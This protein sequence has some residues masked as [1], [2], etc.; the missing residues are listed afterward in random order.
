MGTGAVTPTTLGRPAQKEDGA[1]A[2]FHSK[3]TP[4]SRRR[5]T[6]T[7]TSAS[8]PATTYMIG[9][10]IRH[11]SMTERITEHR[12]PRGTTPPAPQSRHPCPSHFKDTSQNASSAAYQVGTL[13]SADDDTILRFKGDRRHGQQG[14]M[15]V[16]DQVSTSSVS[17][18]FLVTRNLSPDDGSPS[19]R[20]TWRP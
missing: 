16:T 9:R 1:Q 17:I 20:W 4:C 11:D 3:E 6:H 13:T 12:K 18:N 2:M 15:G 8:C 7:S 19:A 10:T 5:P 14:G